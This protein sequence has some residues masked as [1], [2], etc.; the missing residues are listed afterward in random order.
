MVTFAPMF[1]VNYDN[2]CRWDWLYQSNRICNNGGGSRT[3]DSINTGTIKS[4]NQRRFS[5][6]ILLNDGSMKMG[7]TSNPGFKITKEGFVMQQIL[8]RKK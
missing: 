2:Q 8:L 1:L 4:N 6:Q 7:G 5:S 3:V